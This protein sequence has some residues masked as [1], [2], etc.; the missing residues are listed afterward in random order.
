M[1]NNLEG[2]DH[3]VE[4]TTDENEYVYHQLNANQ[5][6]PPPSAEFIVQK[7]VESGKTMLDLVKSRLGDYNGYAHREHVNLDDEMYAFIKKVIVDYQ[8]SNDEAIEDAGADADEVASI[9]SDYIDDALRL[10]DFDTRFFDLN[11]SNEVVW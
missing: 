4:D 9:D 6:K 8:I 5:R 2:H 11:P 7:L 1:F 3:S 10:L